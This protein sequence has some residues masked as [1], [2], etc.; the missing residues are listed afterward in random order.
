LLAKGFYTATTKAYAGETTFRV[1]TQKDMVNKLCTEYR[2]TPTVTLEKSL[3]AHKHGSLFMPG[4][5]S[6]QT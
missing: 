6:V 5:L 4:C 3:L 2:N 1:T